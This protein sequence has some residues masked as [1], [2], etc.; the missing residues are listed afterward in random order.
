[1]DDPIMWMKV[2]DL[3]RAV[4]NKSVAW[5]SLKYLN[6]PFST[7]LSP[8]PKIFFLPKVFASSLMKQAFNLTNKQTMFNSY[9]LF[10]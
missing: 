10:L 2:I 4:I 6:K 5:H 7:F 9:Y 1:M 8:H 3:I